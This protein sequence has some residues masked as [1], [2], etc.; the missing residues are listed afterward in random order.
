MFHEGIRVKP[1]KDTEG[2]WTIGCGRNMEG[3]GFSIEESQMIFGRPRVTLEQALRFFTTNILTPRQVK[4]LLKND[5]EKTRASLYQQLPVLFP[6][7]SPLRQEVLIDMGFMGIQRLLEFN[8]MLAALAEGDY[9][10]AAVEM[11]NSKWSVQVGGRAKRLAHIME[12]NEE[13]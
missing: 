2:I 3:N 4:T 1:Y 5:I 8:K 11:M 13:A 10:K 12:F 7:L 9:E 6:S